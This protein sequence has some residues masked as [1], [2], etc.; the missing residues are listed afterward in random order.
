M[1]SIL[2]ISYLILNLHSLSIDLTEKDL[3]NSIE[4]LLL[5]NENLFVGTTN[6]LHRLS[7]RTLNKS[8]SSFQ[9]GPQ[10][11]NPLCRQLN[12]CND[13]IE[14]NYH[15]KILFSIENQNLL[16]CGTLFQGS[17]QIIDQNFQFIINSSLPIVAN[18]PFNSTIGLIIPE[19]NLIYLGVTYTNE[20]AYRWQIPNIAGRSL[21]ISRFMKILSVNDDDDLIS[22]DDLS[23]KFMPRQQATF[24]VQYIY[25]FYTKNYIYFLSNQPN[26]IEQKNLI[27]KLSRFCRDSSNS[28]IRSYT[29]IPLICVNSEWILKT[30]QIIFDKNNQMILIGH[31]TRNGGTNICSWNI[32]NDIDKA[33]EDNYA[34]CYSMGIGQRGLAFIK[35]NEPCREDEVRDEKEFI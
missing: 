23:L 7:S 30:A 2:I 19:K 15:W 28:I 26:D 11:D 5:I 13:L 3:N 33:L 8:L 22:R 24:I 20:G 18:D 10:L 14:I 9:L 32:K 35:P 12:Q 4:K 16:L 21:N 17:C 25:S 1:F 34:A 27:T 29:E 6:F 31:F